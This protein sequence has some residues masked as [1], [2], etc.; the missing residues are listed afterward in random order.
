[1]HDAALTG[2]CLCGQVR[3]RTAGLPSRI[4]VCHCRWCQQRTGS[5]FGVECVF[6]LEDVQ[7]QGDAPRSWR[8]VSDE[9]GRW[10]E[11]DFC[12]HCGT[13]IGLRLEAVP[14]IRS[15]ALGSFDDTSWRNAEGIAV[16]H[17]FMRSAIGLVAVPAHME[18]YERH[19]R[20]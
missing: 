2:G 20:A 6:A 5:A 3:Y 15:L 9:S 12:G 11:R 13:P 10:L 4:T 17:V 1:M 16:R 19:F 18:R 14:D 7:L 8:T